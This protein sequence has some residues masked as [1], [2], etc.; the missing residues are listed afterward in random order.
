MSGYDGEVK[1]NTRIESRGLNS[2]MM[3]LSNQMEKLARKTSKI[4]EAMNDLEKQNIPTQEYKDI[5]DALHRSN[6]EFDR[7]L[8]RQDSMVAKGKNSGASWDELQRKIE[9]T[10]A[11]I[12]E[13]EK[14]QSQMVKEGTAFKSTK[15][16]DAYN[17]LSEQLYDCNKQMDLLNKKQKE[18]K[19]KQ[20]K[21]IGQAAKQTSGLLSTMLSR[22]KGIALSLLVFNWISKGWNAMVTAIK[23]GVQSMAKYSSDFNARMSEMKSATA[24]LK[25][26]LGTLAAPIISLLTPAIVTLC[27]WLTNVVNAINKFIA[28]VSGKSTWTRAKQQQVDYAKS[29][30]GTAAAAKKAAGALASFDDLNVLQRDD[31]S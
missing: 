5:T 12:R 19:A 20:L 18:L 29:L 16:T 15:E 2:Q 17:K 22:L 23:N 8:Q 14:Y 25:S 1:I 26:S 13:A 7:L 24:T 31:T 21:S 9:R 6:T 10:G 3:Q 28:G 4:K 27:G 30:K 11:D